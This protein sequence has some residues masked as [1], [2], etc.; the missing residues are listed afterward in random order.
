M[1]IR[2]NFDGQP[3][4]QRPPRYELPED[5][6][7]AGPL[8]DFIGFTAATVSEDDFLQ[9]FLNLLKDNLGTFSGTPHSITLEPEIHRVAVLLRPVLLA[10]KAESEKGITVLDKQG[11]WEPVSTSDWAHPMV[12]VPKKGEESGILPT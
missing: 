2:C 1:T 9:K 7:G 8:W 10:L 5:F 3:K 4:I 11:L 12:T 6:G